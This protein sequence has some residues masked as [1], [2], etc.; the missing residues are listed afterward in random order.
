MCEPDQKPT[1]RPTT[2]PTAAPTTQPSP[3]RNPPTSSKTTPKLFARPTTKREP[4]ANETSNDEASRPH[5]S[6]EVHPHLNIIL[7]VVLVIGG[8][9]VLAFIGTVVFYCC[10]LN[11]YRP[12]L[13]KCCAK[14]KGHEENEKNILMKDIQDSPPTKHQGTNKTF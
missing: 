2:I 12:N 8:V 5:S 10:W 11:N 3:T 4:G 9:F 13:K 7:I 1:K 6:S 14:V